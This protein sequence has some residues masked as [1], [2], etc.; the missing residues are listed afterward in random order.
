MDLAVE[1][2]DLDGFGLPTDQADNRTEREELGKMEVAA[3]E[4]ILMIQEELS[5]YADRRPSENYSQVLNAMRTTAVVEQ[6]RGLA[7]AIQR[8]EI[9]QSTVDA[10]YWADVLDR[11]AEELVGPV[12]EHEP[13]SEGLTEMPNL[14]PEIVLEVLRIIHREIELRQETRE[15]EQ[16]R[17]ALGEVTVRQRG[18]ELSQTQRELAERSRELADQIGALP[19]QDAEGQE[20][21]GRNI[22]KLTDAASVMDEV[23]ELLATPVTGPTTLAAI[24][25]VIELL[26]ETDR[27]PNAA[28]VSKAPTST[29]LA[30]M[31]VGLGDD[32][33]QAAIEQRSPGQATGNSGRLLPE[34]FRQGLD[35]Y[36]NALEGRA[37]D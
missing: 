22:Q 13:P 27:A 21:L 16:A 32:N 24:S 31:L 34:E 19:Y 4:R 15:L 25:E 28:M 23:Q 5:A 17:K 1:L 9:G 20:A 12:G 30:L 7:S 11:W 37:N 33:D 18:E 26:L 2:N 14:T 10:D 3:A 8:N 29:T 35:V 6:I 36:F